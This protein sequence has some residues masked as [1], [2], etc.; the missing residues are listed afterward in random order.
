MSQGGGGASYGSTIAIGS[1]STATGTNSVAI[2]N[3]AS[4]STYDDS[5]ALGNGSTAGADNNVAIGANSKC[6]AGNSVA[7]GNNAESNQ[8]SVAI[9]HDCSGGFCGTSIGNGAKS[10]SLSASYGINSQATAYK[11]AAFSGDALADYTSA[12]GYDAI[13]N[14][15][16]SMALGYNAGTG[17]YTNSIALGANSSVGAN[18]VIVLGDG[19]QNVGIGTTNPIKTLS[20]MD[21]NGGMFF[22]LN[23]SSYNRIKSH[24]TYT[25]SGRDLLISPTDAGTSGLYLKSNGNVGIGTTNPS[26]KLQVDGNFF[27]TG[28]DCRFKMN[29]SGNTSHFSYGG[30]GDHY[31]R[32]NS[33]N[34]KVILQDTGGNV[35][36]RTSN[37]RCPLDV[38]SYTRADVDVNDTNDG[39]YLSWNGV[40]WFNNYST[41]NVAICGDDGIMVAHSFFAGYDINFNSDERIKTNINDINDDDALQKLR[42]IQPKTYN[43]KEP[44]FSSRNSNNVYG[45]IAQQIAEVLPNAVTIGSVEGTSNDYIPNI[46]CLCKLTVEND[47][48][49]LELINDVD[50]S[51]II[52]A[53]TPYNITTLTKTTSDFEKDLSDNFNNLLF[54]NK[55][56]SR[57]ECGVNTIISNTKFTINK[58]L[59]ADDMYTNDT[60]LLYGQ[61]AHDFHRLNKDYIFTIATA[62]LQEVDRQLQAEKAKTATLEA[63]MADV[64]ARLSALENP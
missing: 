33:G 46:L 48:Q 2:G 45:F 61:K 41:Q 22:S 37:P 26:Y 28:S 38:K 62:A 27:F 55:S 57:I 58:E 60:I 63:Q 13:C 42:L 18:D 52:S 4:T 9:G 49:I 44:V 6:S 10:G 32:S 14:G 23:E 17:N 20:L 59:T 12:F 19:T 54:I 5:V 29:N 43:Y 3:N 15:V 53:E 24:T 8:Q 50:T 30:N 21:S 64:L 7:L 35:G 16:N 56:T 11:C 34:G 40:N 25:S 47:S 31:I 1:G 39:H 36:I 51:T